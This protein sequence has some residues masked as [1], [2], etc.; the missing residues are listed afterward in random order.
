MR[1]LKPVRRIIFPFEVLP[2]KNIICIR[3]YFSGSILRTGK[4]RPLTIFL[5]LV[6]ILFE[7]IKIKKDK[8]ES[9]KL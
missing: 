3:I 7:Y 5:N 1:R 2:L 4:K 6:P 9:K 8:F